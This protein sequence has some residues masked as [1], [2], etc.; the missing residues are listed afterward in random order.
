[1]NPTLT[2]GVKCKNGSGIAMEGGLPPSMMNPTQTTMDVRTFFTRKTKMTKPKKPTK[3]EKEECAKR[4]AENSARWEAQEQRE[5]EGRFEAEEAKGG[6]PQMIAGLLADT[7][8]GGNTLTA[9]VISK[10]L[11]VDK[12]DVNK[13][14]YGTPEVY[15]FAM[16]PSPAPL[17]FRKGKGEGACPMLD[18]EEYEKYEEME[19]E[20][21]CEVCKHKV[22]AEDGVGCCRDGDCPKKIESMCRFC[23]TWDDETEQWRCEDCGA[24]AEEE[25]SLNCEVCGHDEAVVHDWGCIAL[26]E[27]CS[28]ADGEPHCPRTSRSG[29][30]EQC[31]WCVSAWAKMDGKEEE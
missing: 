19:A 12:H 2:P 23:A 7:R 13:V 4:L 27:T 1:M 3:A 18:W 20:E 28:M 31:E 22:A 26:C 9:K 21:D 5:W 25:D 14:L 8:F 24:E 30:A 11:G 29:E 15:G 10:A 6:L 16:G 17:W